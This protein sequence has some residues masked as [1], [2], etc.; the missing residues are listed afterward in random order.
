MFVIVELTLTAN[1]PD[2]SGTILKYMGSDSPF[3]IRDTLDEALT[4]ESRTNARETVGAMQTAHPTREFRIRKVTQA[5][6]L[7]P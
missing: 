4:Y 3:D 5:L 1:E 2:S 7:V 6:T